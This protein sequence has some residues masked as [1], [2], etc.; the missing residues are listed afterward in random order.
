MS[1]TLLI[2]RAAENLISRPFINR[3]GLAGHYRLVNFQEETV[4]QGMFR[5][6]YFSPYLG[7]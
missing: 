2:D 7:L 3:K 5:L 1:K 4:A 6:L